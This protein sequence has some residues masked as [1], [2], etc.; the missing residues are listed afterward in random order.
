MNDTGDPHD[1]A[2]TVGP[3]VTDQDP[4]VEVYVGKLGSEHARS[5]PRHQRNSLAQRSR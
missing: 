3:L 1:R 4:A 5:T 2:G